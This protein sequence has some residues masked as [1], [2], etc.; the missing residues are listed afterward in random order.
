MKEIYFGSEVFLLLV[1]FALLSKT[2][3]TPQLCIK[4]TNNVIIQWMIP[5]LTCYVV[6]CGDMYARGDIG[7][8]TIEMM[9]NDMKNCVIIEGSIQMMFINTLVSMHEE[10]QVQK[11]MSS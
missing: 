6:V 9:A 1:F 7:E 8:D 2:T 3:R 11:N 4:T 5:Y 10:A